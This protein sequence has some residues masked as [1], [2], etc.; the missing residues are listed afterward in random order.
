MECVPDVMHHSVIPLA[1]VLTI[2]G[3]VYW[4]EV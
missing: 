4:R 3:G 1:P 2:V